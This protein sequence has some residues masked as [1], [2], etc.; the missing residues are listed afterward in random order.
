[1]D[2]EVFDGMTEEEFAAYDAWNTV[3]MFRA[4]MEQ[5]HDQAERDHIAGALLAAEEEYEKLQAA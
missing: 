2:N 3:L 5:A 1:M 4:L